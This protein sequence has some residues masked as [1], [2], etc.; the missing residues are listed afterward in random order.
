MSKNVYK[1]LVRTF[2][3]WQEKGQILA[4][5]CRFLAAFLLS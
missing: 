5:C 4:T 2:E 3:T 1:C